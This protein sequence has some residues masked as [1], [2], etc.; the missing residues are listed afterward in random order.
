M[1]SSPLPRIFLHVQNNPTPPNNTSL[2]PTERFSD[3]V[4]DYV[5]CRP[6]YPDGMIPLIRQHTGLT[7]DWIV[8]D[9]GS[10]TG[11]SSEPFLRNGNIV[12][13][14]EPNRAMRA[15]AEQLLAEWSGFRSVDGSAENTTLA[16]DSID[17]II[18]G[19]A[20]HWFDRARTRVEFMRVGRANCWTV[21]VWN[22]R[23]TDTTPFLEAYEALVDRFGT[24][25]QQVRHDRLD[26]AVLADFFQSEFSVRQLPNSQDFDLAGLSGRLLSSS[27]TPAPNDPRRQPML[28]ELRGIF[29]QHQKDGRVRFDYVTEVVLGRLGSPE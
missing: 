24:D 19:Q 27:Y 10:G 28:D 16:S 26:T 11:I 9:V 6:R 18:V 14:V 22:R 4:T 5:R 20:F 23:E 3:R 25:Y 2:N 29:D 21:L 1:A 17:L 7:S 8:A 15:A 13:A 12:F